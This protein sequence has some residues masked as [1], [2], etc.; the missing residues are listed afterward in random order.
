ME[1]AESMAM[2]FISQDIVIVLFV[3]V[4]EELSKYECEKDWHVLSSLPFVVVVVAVVF[5]NVVWLFGWLLAKY[6]FEGVS[7]GKCKSQIE[8]KLFSLASAVGWTPFAYK[9][10]LS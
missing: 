10:N 4:W 6:E 8:S 9:F 5:V 2:C 3:S 7:S 1:S